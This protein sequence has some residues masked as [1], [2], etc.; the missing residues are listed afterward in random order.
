MRSPASEIRIDRA[1]T[2]IA[3]HPKLVLMSK[4]PYP[5]SNGCFRALNLTTPRTAPGRMQLVVEP[6][7]KVRNQPEPAISHLASNNDLI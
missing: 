5:V 2:D 7:L 3:A 6:L 1:H 4:A